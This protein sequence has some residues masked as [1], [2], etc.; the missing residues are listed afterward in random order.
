[1]VSLVQGSCRKLNKSNNNSAPCS[2]TPQD[3]L[4]AMGQRTLNRYRGR[5]CR[6][7]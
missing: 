5:T 1:M 3:G 6:L 4:S 7:Y 2:P